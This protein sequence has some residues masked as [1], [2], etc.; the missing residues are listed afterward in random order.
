MPD[1]SWSIVIAPSGTHVVTEVNW[2]YNS[3]SLETLKIA[4]NF[5]LPVFSMVSVGFTQGFHMKL[6]F[7]FPEETN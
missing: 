2:K 7:I 3:C 6:L 1:K 5:A 4:C